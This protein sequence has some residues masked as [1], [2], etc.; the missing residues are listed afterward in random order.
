M[1]RVRS[2]MEQ[3]SA[4]TRSSALVLVSSDTRTNRPALSRSET[5]M[6][7]AQ[8]FSPAAEAAV[9]QQV[10]Q[11]YR[12]IAGQRQQHRKNQ[13]ARPTASPAIRPLRLAAGQ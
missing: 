13:I 1:G 12:V 11:R 2:S 5:R 4:A 8:W 3:I 6:A 9:R 10:D 7:F